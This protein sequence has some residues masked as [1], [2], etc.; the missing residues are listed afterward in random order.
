MVY[1]GQICAEQKALAL[2]LKTETQASYEERAK[3]A[4]FQS[5]PHIPLNKDTVTA[6][7]HFSQRF[8]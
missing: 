4:R 5:H 8:Y 2:Y 6:R 3:S 1:N 7:S